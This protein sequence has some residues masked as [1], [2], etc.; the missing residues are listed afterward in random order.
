MKT[1]QSK[2]QIALKNIL[3]AYDFEA[4][5][6]RAFPFA[7]ALATRYGAV[8]YAAHV[9][10]QEVYAVASPES[11]ESEL[12]QAR[13]YAT[14]ALNQIADPLRDR[15]LRCGVLVGEGNVSE[16]IEEFAHTYAADLLCVGTSSRAGLGKVL[17]GSVAEEI[18]RESPC[19]V[20]TVGPHVM[21]LASAGVHR[22]VCATDFS[23]ASAASRR[24]RRLTGE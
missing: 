7:V 10:P 21:A 11:L 19:P 1:L 6:S 14:Y 5:A 23:P 8:L 4:S 13:D 24:I 18:I 16:V 9:I 12:K 17:M 15:G 22:I 20:L 3:F 2:S